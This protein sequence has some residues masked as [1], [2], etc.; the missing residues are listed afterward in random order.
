L[1]AVSLPI[2]ICDWSNLIDHLNVTSFD[3]QMNNVGY[4]NSSK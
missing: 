2:N 4:E 3:I 1:T